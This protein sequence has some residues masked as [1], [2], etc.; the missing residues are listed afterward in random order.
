M[1]VCVCLKDYLDGVDRI[2]HETSLECPI[3]DK[4]VEEGI[5]REEEEAGISPSSSASNTEGELDEGEFE[6]FEVEDLDVQDFLEEHDL[7]DDE[8]SD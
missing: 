3:L 5:Q 8:V 6:E 2:Q 7:D 4:D 1:E